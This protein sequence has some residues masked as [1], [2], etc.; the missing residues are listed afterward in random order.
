VDP[1]T[2]ARSYVDALNSHELEARAELLFDPNAELVPL[3]AAL[4]D[5]VYHG[6]EGIRQ[7]ARDLDES[8]SETHVETLELEVRGAQVLT[9]SR[10]RLKGRASGAWTELTV[11]GAGLMRNGRIRRLALHQMVQDARRELGW[12]S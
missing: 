9:I 6:H 4:E 1:E 10:M 7:F 3:R 11:V 5:T 12:D 8:W 2:L